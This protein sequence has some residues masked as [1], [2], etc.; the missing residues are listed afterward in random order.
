MAIFTNPLRLARTKE[1]WPDA[2]PSQQPPEQ[3]HA[4][5]IQLATAT[6]SRVPLV[7]DDRSNLYFSRL[8]YFALQVAMQCP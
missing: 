6:A 7:S 4:I 8:L 1:A 2:S 3:P 5:T